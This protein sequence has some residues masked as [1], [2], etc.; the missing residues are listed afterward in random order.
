MNM[1]AFLHHFIE[2]FLL[3]FIVFLSLFFFS[4]F[5]NYNVTC[6]FMKIIL[7]LRFMSQKCQRNWCS[8]RKW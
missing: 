1:Y 4:T 3:I 5:M 8:P 2:L 6:M 7:Y